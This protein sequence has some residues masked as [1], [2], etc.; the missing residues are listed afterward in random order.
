MTSPR[1]I[2]L[3]SPAP[4]S[5]KSTVAAYLTEHGFYTV[6]FARHIKL[7]VRTFLIQL[8]YGPSEIDHFLEAG[9]NDVLE[10]MPST[11]RPPLQPTG[12]A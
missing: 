4:R 8:G 10:G 1:L 6:P 5:G 12:T 2:G 11:P 7:M 3:Y 9:Q